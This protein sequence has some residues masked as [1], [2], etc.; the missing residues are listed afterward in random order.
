VL[1]NIGANLSHFPPDMKMIP[2]VYRSNFRD[3]SAFFYTQ[4]FRMRNRDSIYVANAD[5]V[6]VTKFLNYITTITSTVST[7][8]VDGVTTGDAVSGRHILGND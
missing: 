1:E 4:G 3:P 5:S 7:V 6:E 2:T 8:A